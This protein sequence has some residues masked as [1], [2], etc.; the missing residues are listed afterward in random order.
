MDEAIGRRERR[1]QE[2]RTRITQ[3]AVELLSAAPLEDLTVD[4][5]C[6]RADV[7]KKTFY[8]YYPSKQDLIESISQALL[9]DESEKNYALAIDKFKSTRER[10]EFF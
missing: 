4:E 3:A 7:A 9:I 1:K 5:L 8:N 10:L 6:E 2:V